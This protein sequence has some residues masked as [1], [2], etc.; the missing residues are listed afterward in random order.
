MIS[1]IILR[2]NLYETTTISYEIKSSS[3]A[4]GIRRMLVAAGSV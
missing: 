3:K 1:M 2:G 4:L